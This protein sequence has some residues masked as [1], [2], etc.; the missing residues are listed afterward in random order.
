M[1]LNK[2]LVEM[3]ILIKMK[4]PIYSEIDAKLL[5]E[6]AL[7]YRKKIDDPQKYSMDMT[8]ELIETG[9]EDIT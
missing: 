8:L 4:S 3:V 5:Q 9:F 7:K 2:L 6:I 1:K